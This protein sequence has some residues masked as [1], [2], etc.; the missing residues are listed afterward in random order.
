MSFL[1]TLPFLEYDDFGISSVLAVFAH[2][3]VVLVAG[4]SEA[5]AFGTF[6]KFSAFTRI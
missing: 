4:D 2:E 1:K 6:S 3:N 5:A